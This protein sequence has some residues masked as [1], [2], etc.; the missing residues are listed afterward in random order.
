MTADEAP[1]KKSDT[2]ERTRSKIEAQIERQQEIKKREQFS[3]RIDIARTGLKE[4]EKRKYGDAAKSFHLYLKV[5]EEW[6]DVGSEGL[7][8]A[9]FD[10]KKDAAE[11]VLIVGVYWDLAKL[12]DRTQSERKQDEFKKCLNKYVIFAKNTPM[13]GICAESL[14]KYISNEKPLHKKDFQE[15][16]KRLGGKDCF[17]ASE[18]TGYVSSG[19]V[20]N[21]RFFRDEKLL[22]SKAGRVFVRSYYSVGPWIAR[23][24]G[25]F[26]S[27]LKFKLAQRLDRLSRE[28]L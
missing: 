3:R 14:R 27:K 2:F 10:A 23:L 11:L 20:E 6:K 12:Y 16:Y 7:M 5:L 18:L 17:V 28:L 26:P 19:T 22:P 21:L 4:Y 9:H 15:A 24:V 8:P 25:V 1:P 13:E